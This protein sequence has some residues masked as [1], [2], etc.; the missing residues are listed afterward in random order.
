MKW[1]HAPISLEVRI[2]DL[3]T[4]CTW[5]LFILKIMVFNIAAFMSMEED[6]LY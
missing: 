5:R 1:A 2:V 6:C 3:E 4:I